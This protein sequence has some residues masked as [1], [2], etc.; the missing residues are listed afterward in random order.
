MFNTICKIFK[1][2]TYTIAMIIAIVGL[3]TPGTFSGLMQDL[4]Q[5]FKW[6][7]CLLILILIYLFLRINIPKLVRK[8]ILKFNGVDIKF[9]N[10]T[11]RVLRK[12]ANI[13]QKALS[14]DRKSQYELITEFYEEGDTPY[15][16]PEICFHFTK[17]IAEEDT[18]LGVIVEL[19]DLYKYGSGVKKD[20]NKALEIYKHALYL[21]D[22]PTPNLYIPGSTEYRQFL[23][24]QIKSV[25]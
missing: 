22:N 3:F 24:D 8:C 4:I 6:G 10:K 14:N 5:G 7:A 23:I 20:K 16:I 19:G 13:I 11:Y 18:D 12:R 2:L 1:I 25:K 21:Y 17:L 15:F 9:N